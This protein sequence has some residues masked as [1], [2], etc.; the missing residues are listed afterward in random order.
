MNK[1]KIKSVDD[2]IQY[3]EKNIYFG[4]KDINGN[5]HRDSITGFSDLYSYM[6][7]EEV[8]KEKIGS[9]H[10]QVSL[11]K[12]LLALI[13]IKSTLFC[14][15]VY[16]DINEIPKYL[17]SFIIFKKEGSFNMIEH[18]EHNKR[19]LYTSKN[20]DDLFDIIKQ[21]YEKKIPN[22][23]K[24]IYVYDELPNDITY[25]GLDKYLT[26]EYNNLDNILA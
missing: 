23:I 2:I 26:I 16:D 17:H 11:I 22:S 14:C 25:K 5:F 24:K 9:C 18:A 12:E 10:E 4:W 6:T 15:K 3:L 8:K 20:I 21:K 1:E 19:I 7:N 13:N